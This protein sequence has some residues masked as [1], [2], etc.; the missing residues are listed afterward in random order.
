MT[1]AP[2]SKLHCHTQHKHTD[3]QRGTRHNVTDREK[4]RCTTVP[5][6]SIG[7]FKIQRAGNDPPD[8]RAACALIRVGERTSHLLETCREEQEK[9][10]W[11]SWLR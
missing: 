6:T 9:Q 8:R 5:F 3:T 10:V 1:G 2:S 4:H 7:W 11:S